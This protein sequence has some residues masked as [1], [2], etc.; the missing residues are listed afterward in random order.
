MPRAMKDSGI[1]WIGFIPAEW[2]IHQI[3]N[4]FQIFSGA[5]PKSEVVENWDGDIVWI[6]PADYKTADKYVSQGKR[7]I[8]K[9]GYNSCG[10]TFVPSGSIIFSKRAPIGTVAIT[11]AE[12]CTNQ[13][14]LSCVPKADTSSSY[15]YYVLSAFTEQFNLFGTGTT[16][17]EI[18]YNDFRSFKV[19]VPP[20]DEQQRIADYL[21][22]ECARI[23]S[24]VEKTRASIVEYKKLK[25]ALITRAVTKGIRPA[26]PMKDS[27]IEWIGDVPTNWE[28]IKLKYLF[29]IIGG[30]GFPDILQGN[31]TGDYPF[32]KVS[33]INGEADYVD[34]AFNWVSQS[35]VDDNRFNVIPIGSIIMAKIGAALAKNHR[36]IN[37]VRCCIDNN[38]Q[39]LVPKR[40]DDICYLLYL[41]K[42][43]DMSWFD[44]NST[45]PS[46]NN[47]KLLN[48]FVP[49]PPLD[50]Q[51]RIA[52]FLDDKCARIDSVI[53]KKGRLVTELE[54]LKKSLIF[55]YVTG[56]KEAPEKA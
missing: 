52:S 22:G 23:D 53:E 14:C 46:I 50:E 28:I 47:P 48:F 51:Q 15:Y 31:T 40:K 25:Q 45:V 35:V 19:P 32:C 11:A 38:T 13:G 12:L 18:S 2:K 33:D 8:S 4:D 30:N 49:S 5:T 20:L 29:S 36:K 21:D 56:K 24:I 26:R 3:K 43:I 37:T 41:S 27:G 16:F 6:T 55:E 44:N 10:T 54:R 17:K 34:T 42:C 9:V 39:A 1:K 7:N